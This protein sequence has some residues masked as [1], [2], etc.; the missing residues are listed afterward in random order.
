PFH[1]PD[2]VATLWQVERDEPVPPH[3]LQPGV[4]RDLETVCLKCLEKE[5]AKR[6]ASAAA[7]ADDLERFLGGR[8]V[9]ARPAPAWERAAKWAR[10]RPAA[11]LLLAVARVVAGVGFAA[12]PA[13]GVRAGRDG[14]AEAP[15][16][17][18]AGA[19][20][21]D[22]SRTCTD[23]ASC[24][25]GTAPPAAAWRRGPTTPPPSGPPRSAPTAGSS[26][27]APPTAH[28]G[29]PT[30]PPAPRCPAAP[31]APRP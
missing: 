10:R 12:G 22:G 25:S 29:W 6:Y 7:L 9:L 18:P 17:Q 5:P 28:S 8:P 21:A 4:P 15:G 23:R 24:A 26:P 30:P 11:A 14:G 19:E 27:P 3:R 20:G 2:P 16:G 1:G 31:V 13:L